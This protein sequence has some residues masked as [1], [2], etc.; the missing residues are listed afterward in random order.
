MPLKVLGDTRY[1]QVRIML[2]FFRERSQSDDLDIFNLE[3][4]LN[5]FYESFIEKTEDE[6]EPVDNIEEPFLRKQGTHG[7]DCLNQTLNIKRKEGYELA[8]DFKALVL[9]SCEFLSLQYYICM[10]GI[11]KN[12][13]AFS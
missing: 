4:R 2:L 10:D 3:E 1:K 11:Y 5:E 6:S 8:R 12:I 13:E 9:E 7:F